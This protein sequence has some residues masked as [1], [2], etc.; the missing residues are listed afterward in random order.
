MALTVQPKACQE[1]FPESPRGSFEA[2]ARTRLTSGAW[3][4]VCLANTDEV[5]PLERARDAPRDSFAPC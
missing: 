1:A 3:L 2:V 5:D 4:S